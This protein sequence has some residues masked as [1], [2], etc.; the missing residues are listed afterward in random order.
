MPL[1]APG[2]RIDDNW[3]TMG[4]R[5]TGSNDVTIEGV[6]VPEG[7]AA[8]RRPKGKWGRFFDVISPLVQPLIMSVYVGVAESAR[9][10]ALAQAVKKRDDPIAQGL[11]GEMDTHLAAAQIALREMVALGSDSDWQPTLERSNRHQTRRA[12]RGTRPPRQK[13]TLSWPGTYIELA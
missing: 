8:M 1:D 11:V 10:L 13:R 7:A 3:R 12:P 6:F 4:M 9:P 2:V 5:A